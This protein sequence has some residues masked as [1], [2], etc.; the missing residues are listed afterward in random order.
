[1]ISPA[2]VVP[3]RRRPIVRLRWTGARP[4]F[5]DWALDVPELVRSR[6]FW[7]SSPPTG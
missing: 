4:G 6:L 3:W 2:D 7:P 5:L 1:V